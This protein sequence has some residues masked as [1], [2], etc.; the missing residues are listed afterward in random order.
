[1]FEGYIARNSLINQQW[2]EEQGH[3]FLSIGA[4]Q[5]FE[6]LILSEPTGYKVIIILSI[7]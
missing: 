4:G 1:M 3:G 5:Q 7:C 6:F 2:G